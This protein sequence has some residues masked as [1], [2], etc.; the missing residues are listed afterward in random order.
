MKN[1]TKLHNKIIAWLE[2]HGFVA[3]KMPGT[4][5]MRGLP[6]I[7]AI[8]NGRVW[9]FE[10]KTS[11]GKLS[12]MQKV[13]L[14]KLAKFG[15]RCSVVRSV[16]ENGVKGARVWRVEPADHEDGDDDGNE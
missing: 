15:A 14:E 4:V 9:F 8:R 12:H 5:F 6:D 11:K 3:V 16:E 10:V 2:K 1:E 13:W 7:L